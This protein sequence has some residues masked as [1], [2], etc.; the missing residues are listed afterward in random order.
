[1]TGENVGDTFQR[2]GTLGDEMRVLRF[3]DLAS[4][5]LFVVVGDEQLSSIIDLA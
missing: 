5:L 4:L 3:G 2:N 1:M